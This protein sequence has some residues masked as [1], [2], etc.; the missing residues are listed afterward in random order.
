MK[1]KPLRGLDL[2]KYRP[3][4][5]VI[6]SDDEKHEQELNEMLLPAGYVRLMKYKGNIYYAS[7]AEMK[8]RLEPMRFTNINL[9]H[10]AHPLDKQHDEQKLI[11]ITLQE[12]NAPALSWRQKLSSFFRKQ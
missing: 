9:V 7:N 6:E 8:S 11:T 3:E 5:M 12:Q 2:K 1:Y 4:V 10:T